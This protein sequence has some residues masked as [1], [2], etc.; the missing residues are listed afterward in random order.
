MRSGFF[1]SLLSSR[2][3][4]CNSNPNVF[5]V[6]PKHSI[7]SQIHSEP[8]ESVRLFELQQKNNKLMREANVRLYFKI[9]LT[10]IRAKE[11]VSHIF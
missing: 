4:T 3:I 11:N 6:Y 8:T 2:E 7:R 1:L 9:Y 10:L 5:L